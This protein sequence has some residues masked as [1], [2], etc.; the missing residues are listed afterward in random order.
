[1]IVQAPPKVPPMPAS[2]F[3]NRP[4]ATPARS[5]APVLPTS[6]PKKAMT[7][8]DFESPERAA[9]K[10]PEPTAVE[11]PSPEAASDACSDVVHPM[12]S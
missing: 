10:T 9:F 11:L 7:D 5:Q 8:S 6:D 4:V 3:H 2:L 12:F 1:M